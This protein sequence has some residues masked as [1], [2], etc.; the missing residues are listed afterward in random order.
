MKRLTA[1]LLCALILVSA[2]GCAKKMEIPEN[3]LPVLM[4]HNIVPDGEKVEG[5]TVT[6]SR[7]R[8]D[9]QWLID[10]DYTFV[11]PKELAAGE[12]PAKPVLVTFDDGYRTNYEYLF[13]VLKEM[14]VKAAIAV[15]VSRIDMESDVFLSWDMCREMSQS[16]LVEIG[17]HTYDLHN[18]DGRG[19]LYEKG[20]VNGIQRREDES[21]DDYAD[22]VYGDLYHSIEVLEEQLGT[23]VRYFAYPFGVMCMDATGFIQTHFDVTVTTLSAVWDLDQGL[24]DMARLTITMEESVSDFLEP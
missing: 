5:M 21:R 3:A 9:M 15:I 6:V 1:L 10:H 7:F 16:G 19:G 4:Y 11:L 2:P 12:C 20:G 22:R 23:D 14:D 17:S 8:E 18:F 24:H 13:P